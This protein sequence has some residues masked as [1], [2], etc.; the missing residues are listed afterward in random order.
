MVMPTKVLGFLDILAI[1]SGGW[2]PSLAVVMAAALTV[3]GVGYVLLRPG[4][5]LFDTQFHLPTQAAIDRPLFVGSVLFGAG[6]GLVGLSG[7]GN[8][9]PGH[10]VDARYRLRRRHG[11]RHDRA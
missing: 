2:D 1:A 7:A 11:G 4:A 6:W 8:R 9:E 10:P 5:P 3:S